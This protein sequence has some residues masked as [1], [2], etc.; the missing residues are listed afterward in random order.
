MALATKQRNLFALPDTT[1]VDENID[2][3]LKTPIDSRS[4]N[5]DT[6][7]VNPPSLNLNNITKATTTTSRTV[8]T[9]T[10]DWDSTITKITGKIKPKTPKS[11]KRV[12][13]LP[14]IARRE[15]ERDEEVKNRYTLEQVVEERPDPQIVYPLR[16]DEKPNLRHFPELVPKR[17]KVRRFD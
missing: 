4:T 14:D 8:N 11:A 2:N 13:G 10:F 1:A 9:V 3:F 12:S 17:K 7:F 15:K 6:D 5:T 16:K